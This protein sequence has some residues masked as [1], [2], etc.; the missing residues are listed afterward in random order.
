MLRWLVCSTGCL[1]ISKARRCFRQVT[2]CEARS[3]GKQVLNSVQW[4]WYAVSSE[5]EVQLGNQDTIIA[6]EARQP[7][8]IYRANGNCV[9]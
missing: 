4:A 5:P 9:A 6:Q 7:C 1:Y 8:V 2:G 3:V